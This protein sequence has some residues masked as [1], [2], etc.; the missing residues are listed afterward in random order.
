MTGPGVMIV[1][2]PIFFLLASFSHGSV[3]FLLQALG[4][5]IVTRVTFRLRV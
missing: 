2:F 4:F 1:M 5:F 3:F